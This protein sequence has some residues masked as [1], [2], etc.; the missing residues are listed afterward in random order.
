LEGT[1]LMPLFKNP[2]SNW[3]KPA[4]SQMSRGNTTGYS[5]RTQRYRYTEWRQASKIVAQE[6]YDYDNDP[7]ETTNIA[8]DSV[9]KELIEKLSKTMS[10][11]L[12]LK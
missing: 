12:N 4:F 2:D 9:N 8:A 11:E 6:L 1:S 7:Y 10:V 3:N 5:I